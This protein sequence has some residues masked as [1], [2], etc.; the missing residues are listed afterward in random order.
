[1]D[2]PGGTVF[3]VRSV[4]GAGPAIQRR[5]VMCRGTAL[6]LLLLLAP[7]QAYGRAGISDM[8]RTSEFWIANP[9]GLSRNLDYPREATLFRGTFIKDND[10]LMSERFV[11]DEEIVRGVKGIARVNNTAIVGDTFAGDY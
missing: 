1:M 7:S 8:A 4:V 6:L 3:V 9:F 5:S 11:H 10:W 2:R